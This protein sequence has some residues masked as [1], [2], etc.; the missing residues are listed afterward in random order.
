MP[1]VV[2]SHNPAEHRYEAHLDGELAGFAA[3]RAR[4]TRW[5]IF[6]HT[7]VDPTLR[8][9]RASARPWRGSLSTTYAPPGTREVLPLCPFIKG[10]IG[11]HPDYAGPRPRVARISATD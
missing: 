7:E 2:T 6:T 4:P 5:S 10:W 1:D 3:L 9:A 11:K 8:G